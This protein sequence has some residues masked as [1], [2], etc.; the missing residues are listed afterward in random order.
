MV[1]GLPRLDQGQRLEGLVER[2]EASREADEGVGVAHEH[3][4]AHEEVVEL[5]SEVD[6]GIQPL[7]GWQLD[8][9]PHREGACLA[10]ASVRSLHC[11]GPAAGDHRHPRLADRAPDLAGLL[12]LLVARRGPRRPEHADGRTNLGELVEALPELSLDPSEPLFL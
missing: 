8:V 10:G 1:E 2:A 12:V 3:Q 7:L 11:P 6:V 5:D 9:E 4:L